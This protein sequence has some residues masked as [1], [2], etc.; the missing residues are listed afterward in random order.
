MP[1]DKLRSIEF[2]SKGFVAEC[3]AAIGV[4]KAFVVI[5]RKGSWRRNAVRRSVEELQ[6]KRPPNIWIAVFDKLVTMKLWIGISSAVL[7]GWDFQYISDIHLFV[8]VQ[9]RRSSRDIV[10]S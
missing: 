6:G 2:A 10:S 1:E 9:P 7:A 4:D 8:Y 3:K 5:V